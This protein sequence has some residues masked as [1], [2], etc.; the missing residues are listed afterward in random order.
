M[1]RIDWFVGKSFHMISNGL[2]NSFAGLILNTNH[3]QGIIL[4][5]L[6]YKPIEFP[7]MFKLAVNTLITLR[8]Y[9]VRHGH[10]DL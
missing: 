10:G 9:L 4:V 8:I 7:L 6:F 5:F 1:L 3:K 2:F